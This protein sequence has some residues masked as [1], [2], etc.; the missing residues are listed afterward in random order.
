M[1]NDM[2]KNEYRNLFSK[3][4]WLY[5]CTNS[6]WLLSESNHFHIYN[7]FQTAACMDHSRESFLHDWCASLN[8]DN[9]TSNW[10]FAYRTTRIY[11]YKRI[12]KNKKRWWLSIM[13]MHCILL[14]L[15]SYLPLFTWRYHFWMT[16]INPSLLVCFCWNIINC[17]Q[18]IS[19]NDSPHR[20][21]DCRYITV[22]FAVK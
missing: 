20:M 17:R 1:S 11:G 12:Y 21:S 8:I 15:A 7:K 10:N 3:F 9:T 2:S 6:Y 14:I 18:A 22:L 5:C 16:N 4:I 19:D 13:R